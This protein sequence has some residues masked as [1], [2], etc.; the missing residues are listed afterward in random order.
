M[1]VP[2]PILKA[3]HQ[4]IPER[5]LAEGSGAVWTV[6]VQGEDAEGSAFTSS[7]FNYSG[8]MGARLAKPGPSATCYPTGVAAVPVEILEAAMPIVFDRRELRRGS[9]GRGRSRGG[10][11]QVIGFH[12]R[13]RA[14]WLLN[15][16][17]SRLDRGPDGLEGG[18]PGAPGRF[19]VNGASVS[20]SKKMLMQPDDHVLLE[21]PGGGGYGPADGAARA[22]E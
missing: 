22:A 18:D 12:M 21:T 11:G 1:F 13:T 7:M 16:V 2:M 17:P 3:L 4:V 20:E 8:G 9:G 6:Q 5:V 19:L 15:A 10:D 14:P